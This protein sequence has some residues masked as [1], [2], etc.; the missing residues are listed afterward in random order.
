MAMLR[1]AILFGPESL[2]I[3]FPTTIRTGS[4]AKTARPQDLSQ[5]IERLASR[6]RVGGMCEHGADAM[7]GIE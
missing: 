7:K 2:I 4:P 5:R 1:K 3:H 6:A